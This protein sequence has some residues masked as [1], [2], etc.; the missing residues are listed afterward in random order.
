MIPH[1]PLNMDLMGG[2]GGP[3]GAGGGLQGIPEGPVLFKLLMRRLLPLLL[4]IGASCD[5]PPA[6]ETDD[7]PTL[8]G[9]LNDPD[10]VVRLSLIHIS[11]PTRLLSISYAV[12]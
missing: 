1:Q 8:Q 7:V 6:P 11:E 4:A 9:K 12:F 3:I 10:P 5:R 2:S